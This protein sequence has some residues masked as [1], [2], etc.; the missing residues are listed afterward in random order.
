MC[1]IPTD[2]EKF[3]HYFGILLDKNPLWG[4]RVVTTLLM[5]PPTTVVN[6][7]FITDLKDFISLKDRQGVSEVLHLV[8]RLITMIGTIVY[9]NFSERPYFSLFNEIY[10]CDRPTFKGIVN[11]YQFSSVLFFEQQYLNYYL[12]Y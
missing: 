8:C 10:N 6:L 11:F 1:H 2:R 3:W 9:Y 12:C 4:S 7:V 5:Q